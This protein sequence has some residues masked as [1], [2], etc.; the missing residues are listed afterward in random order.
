MLRQRPALLLLAFILSSLFV[1]A[2]TVP[3]RADEPEFDALTNYIQKNYQAKR[4]KVPF[5]GLAR[6]A[7]KIIRPAGVK[8]FKLA[9]FKNL[10]HTNAAPDTAAR[11]L[12]REV[13]PEEWQPL[14]RVRADTGEEVYV[15][16]RPVGKDIKVLLASIDKDEAFVARVRFSPQ[17]LAKWMQ[18]PKIMSISL[19]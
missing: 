17:A 1:C 14:V 10:Q 2:A 5:L 11:W 9:T 13:L 4:V 18:D 12:M 16:A 6:F 15:Y 7:V 3:A 19:R 8:S